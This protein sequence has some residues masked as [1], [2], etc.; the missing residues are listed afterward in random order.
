MNIV[1]KM[2]IKK[3]ETF[4]ARFLIWMGIFFAVFS[5]GVSFEAYNVYVSAVQKTSMEQIRKASV[6]SVE[7]Y[8]T[9]FKSVI[10]VSGDV[11]EYL[12][13]NGTNKD[14]GVTADRADV[15]SFL[16]MVVSLKD[17]VQDIGLFD[18]DGNYCLGNSDFDS[19]LNKPDP[20][21]IAR[22]VA[23]PST[24]FFSS[25]VESVNN[26]YYFTLTKSAN[27]YVSS[28]IKTG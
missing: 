19:S 26:T 15:A 25:F 8:N 14:L 28:A 2:K 13:G 1:K 22:A 24:S 12:D 16:N 4:K 7:N 6:Q 10:A 23:N 11:Q 3:P 27:F 21:M 20:A 9:Y 18:S 17:E 5:I